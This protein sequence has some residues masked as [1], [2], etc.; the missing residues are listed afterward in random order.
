MVKPFDYSKWDHIEC[1]D[2]DTETL[3]KTIDKK[4]F[5]KFQKDKRKDR[6][7]DEEKKRLKLEKRL[8]EVKD[9]LEQLGQAGR[10]HA[11]GKKL[12]DEQKEIETELERLERL[13]HWN[14]EN[15]CH[16]VEDKTEVTSYPETYDTIPKSKSSKDPPSTTQSQIGPSKHRLEDLQ[17]L[18]GYSDFCEKYGALADNFVERLGKQELKFSEQFLLD[19]PMLLSEHSTTYMMLDCLEKEMNGFHSEM[20]TAARQ[21]QLVVQCL[22]LAASANRPAQDGVKVIYQRFKDDD[23]S[24]D[25][26]MEEVDR[27]VKK[28]EAR[29]VTKKAEMDAADKGRE[30]DGEEDGEMMSD[31]P[32]VNEVLKE[33]PK[34]MRDAFFK[35]DVQA[36]HVAVS[37]LPREEGKYYMRRCEEVGLWNAG[38]GEEPPYRQEE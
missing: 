2:D 14:W 25:A 30:S 17:M 21:Q 35:Q 3:P 34:E 15:I 33:I 7:V 24:I 18:E 31:D 20:V 11:A 6:D 10:Q 9:K 8:V 4:S 1:S 36:L 13:R 23:T 16:T 27:F 28:V 29:A 19:N 38:E 37:R 12:L 22:E 26:F 5:E 32:K